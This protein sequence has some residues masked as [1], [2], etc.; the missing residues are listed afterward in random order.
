MMDGLAGQ[1][2]LPPQEGGSMQGAMPSVEEIVAL[3][4]QGIPPEQIMEMG[5]PEEMLMEAL[6][7][8][9]R[10]MAAQAAPEQGLATQ[11][12]MAQPSY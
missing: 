5:V 12:A 8:L 1:M 6:S 4:M 3:L 11:S 2:A 9:E 7:L 10:Q